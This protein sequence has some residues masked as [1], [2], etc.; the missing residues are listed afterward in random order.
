M[1]ISAGLRETSN[2]EATGS[3]PVGRAKIH[4]I[5]TAYTTSALCSK[6]EQC[7]NKQQFPHNF[8]TK[9]AHYV[10][11]LFSRSTAAFQ[12][13]DTCKKPRF[14]LSFQHKKL[15]QDGNM[16]YQFTQRSTLYFEGSTHE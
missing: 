1:S 5:S 3:T 10:L 8:C 7:G 16:G 9:S 4:Y 13:A 15:E 11:A 6:P 12:C 2:L 14:S